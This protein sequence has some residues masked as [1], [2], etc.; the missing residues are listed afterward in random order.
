MST[1]E[2]ID[3]MPN[4]EE[5]DQALAAIQAQLKSYTSPLFQTIG[6]GSG[7]QQDNNDNDANYYDRDVMEWMQEEIRDTS[8]MTSTGSPKRTPLL[9]RAGTPIMSNSSSK[10]NLRKAATGVVETP[11]NNNDENKLPRDEDVMEFEPVQTP[12]TMIQRT[13]KPASVSTTTT[14]LVL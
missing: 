4:E 7:Q 9:Q 13:F 1:D 8:P 14:L 5:T 11:R 12:A 10:Q 3:M 2:D 6:G